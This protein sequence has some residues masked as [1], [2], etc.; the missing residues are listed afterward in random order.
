MAESME[1]RQKQKSGSASKKDPVKLLQKLTSDPTPSTTEALR[2]LIGS[3]TVVAQ[4]PKLMEAN[5]IGVLL[6]SLTALE[7][8]PR[9]LQT[10][11]E[12]MGDLLATLRSIIQFPVALSLV[13]DHEGPLVVVGCFDPSC[14]L[15]VRHGALS[16]LKAICGAGSAAVVQ[17]VGA[18]DA[19][20]KTRL[21]R[22]KFE[23]LAGL[24]QSCPEVQVRLAIAQLVTLLL[25]G[26]TERAARVA[27]RND[28]I[29][30]GYKGVLKE[31]SENATLFGDE[32]R[33]KFAEL[34]EEFVRAQASDETLVLASRPRTLSV[35]ES[36]EKDW[37]QA[38]SQCVAELNKSNP[39]GAALMKS[40]LESVVM[41]FGRDESS[42]W[43]WQ[44]G[45]RLARM[46]T[47]M[48]GDVQHLNANFDQDVGAAS[49]PETVLA[50]LL[51]G[52]VAQ[53]RV[54]T[55]REEVYALRQDIADLS[56]AAETTIVDLQTELDT[57]RTKSKSRHHKRKTI[58]TPSTGEGKGGEDP[59]LT[60]R[61]H[62][63]KTLKKKKPLSSTPSTNPS[64]PPD[65]GTQDEGA[66]LSA[67]IAV[68]AS[69]TP[70]VLAAAPITPIRL[71]ESAVLLV[72]NDSTPGVSDSGDS[73]SD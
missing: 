38:V 13:L 42:L 34:L 35:A 46:L 33:V 32:Y 66:T 7:G 71:P 6:A 21:E 60:S 54:Q 11:Q 53:D 10:D 48:K 67:G 57:L 37:G 50:S 43:Q 70:P 22:A 51:L 16:F 1:V 62:K 47:T 73:D 36:D 27:M 31:L 19:Y 41:G 44:C 24:F 8:K 15:V 18:W 72:S 17:V 63:G 26:L 20:R 3:D 52:A 40:I 45:D 25:A 23:H 39:K 14:D 49:S 65:T 30:M 55:L 2:Q 59:P 68:V 28:L 64:T 61:R 4:L 9:K 69:S 5:V 29:H 58:K 12:M 56:Q